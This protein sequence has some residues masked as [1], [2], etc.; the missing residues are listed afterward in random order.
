MLILDEPTTGV[1]PL[2]RRQFWELVGHIRARRPAMSVLVATAHMDE[3]EGF[4]WLVAMDAG[5]V[6]AT[7]SPAELK[8]RTAS[9]TLEQAFISLLP[10]DKP[11][12]TMRQRVSDQIDQY[13]FERTGIAVEFQT[14]GLIDSW[15][16][17]RSFSVR[18]RAS[19]ST[20]VPTR[21]K[22]SSLRRRTPAAASAASPAGRIRLTI[23]RT[24]SAREH[25]AAAS[26]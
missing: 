24:P 6:L 21:R 22:R 18:V 16:S 15:A 25:S 5:R 2:S 19:I 20:C 4:D 1:D 23:S 7:G 17:R 10:D 11:G 3:A 12:E 13:L 14:T 8:A 9:A 26:G